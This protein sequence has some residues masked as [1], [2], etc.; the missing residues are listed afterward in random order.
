MGV[1]IGGGT[2]ASLSASASGGGSGTACIIS[3]QW[4]MSA[5]RQDVYCLG[6]YTPNDTHSIT[7]PQTTLN[8]TLYSPGP[9]YETLGSTTCVSAPRITGSVMPLGCGA[10]GGG[11]GVSGMFW[12]V[13]YSYSKQSKDTPGQESWSMV[14]YESTTTGTAIV[15]TVLRG[16]ATGQ[17]TSGSGV[18]I[19]ATGKTT[20]ATG[21][22]SANSI[23]TSA[24]V[25]A[26]IVIQVG[27]GDGGTKEGGSGNASIPYNVLYI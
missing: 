18:V 3:A 17:G 16:A 11:N 12:V 24:S 15:P 19:H 4:G 23:G 9:T 1:I 26:G 22:I 8:M 7:K 25:D 14:R 2:T 13:G 5:N 21:S 20:G 6:S 27:G 10:G